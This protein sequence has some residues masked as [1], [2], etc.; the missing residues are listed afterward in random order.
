MAGLNVPNDFRVEPGG[1][2]FGEVWRKFF[3]AIARKVSAG[4]AIATVTTA[5]ASD[6]TTTQALVNELKAKV[7]ALIAAQ[8]A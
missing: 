3:A 5:D 1:P 2:F 8:K 4:S 6:P 7:N